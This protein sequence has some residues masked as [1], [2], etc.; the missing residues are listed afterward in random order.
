MGKILVIADIKGEGIATPR[1]LQLAEKLGQDV[2]VVAFVYA[3]LRRLK[4]SESQ[5]AELRERLLEER[6]AEVQGR[7]DRS[8]REGQ[9]VTLKVV[10]EKDIVKWVVRACARGGYMGVIKTGRRSESLVHTATDWQLL[11]ECP[12][13]VL[14]VAEK[15]WHK[16]KPVLAALDL[17]SS[18]AA[19][20]KLNHKILESASALA[21]ALGV[22][23]EIVSA[24]QIPSLL[25]DLDIVDPLAY[26]KDVREEMTPHIQELAAAFNLPEK[27]FYTKRGPAAKVITSRAASIRAQLVVMGTVARK[28]VRA[29]L[30]GNTA[31]EVLRHLHTDVL[32]IKPG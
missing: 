6:R 23:L 21:E 7:I 16:T 25:A 4:L 31:E 17:S 22:E 15:K 30:L 3:S 26:A 27:A 5:G 20:R 9:K 14:I 29:R 2:E 19:K 24:I 12:T 8:K 11:R 18:V 32:A 13:P 10:W 28:G 1:G